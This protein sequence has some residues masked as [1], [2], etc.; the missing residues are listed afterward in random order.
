MGQMSNKIMFENNTI[1]QMNL[2]K[3]PELV[4]SVFPMHCGHHNDHHTPSSGGYESCSETCRQPVE[5]YANT[6][7]LYDHNTHNHTKEI[8]SYYMFS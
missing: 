8:R 1:N 6:A 3:L 7:I 5:I 2:T 4:S